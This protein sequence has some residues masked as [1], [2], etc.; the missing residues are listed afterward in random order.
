MKL[1]VIKKELLEKYIK[2]IGV[3]SFLVLLTIGVILMVIGKPKKNEKQQGYGIGN[4]NIQE[5][6]RGYSLSD[7]KRNSEGYCTKIENSLK[8]MIRKISGVEEV[9][10]VITL[11]T[12][13]EEVVLKDIPYEKEKIGKEELYCENEETVMLEDE[14]GNTHPYI[15]KEINPKVEGVVVGIRTVNEQVK[16]DVMEVVQVLFDIPIHKIK[17]VDIN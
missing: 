6:N 11:K 14:E 3:K 1:E 13:K 12:S 9:E 10:V 2:K 7:N 4:E 5:K 15:V 17:I 8:R 16:K